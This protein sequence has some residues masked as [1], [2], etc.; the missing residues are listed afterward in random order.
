MIEEDKSLKELMLWL[1]RK[2][3]SER[4]IEDYMFY[5]PK[6]KSLIDLNHALNQEAINKFLNRYNNVVSRA[7]LRSYL[8]FVNRL[9]IEIPKITG[10]KKKKLPK[11]LTLDEVKALIDGCEYDRDKLMIAILFEGGL[12]K[13][14]LMSI[15]VKNI[16]FTKRRIKVIGKGNKERMVFLSEDTSNKL[17]EFIERYKKENE[18]YLIRIGER[19][20]YDIINKKAKQILDKAISPHTLRHSTATFLLENGWNLREIQE[21]LGHK[22]LDTVE[23]YTHID[24]KRLKDKFDEVFHEE[25]LRV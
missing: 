6:L 17:K 22:N 13:G 7:F 12:R 10:T 25:E 21:Y 24:L 5:Y 9:D 4:S 1:E 11:F 19:R 14:E 23:I 2:G 3:L 20:I 18:D 15:Q 16:A 8:A